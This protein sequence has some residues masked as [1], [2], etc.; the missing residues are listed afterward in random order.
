MEKSHPSS[1]RLVAV[2]GHVFARLRKRRRDKVL[3]LAN[4]S[5][6]RSV[7][8]CLLTCCLVFDQI[9]LIPYKNVLVGVVI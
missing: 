5:L 3:V 6:S 8:L 1:L 9:V 2:A 4:G 7:L